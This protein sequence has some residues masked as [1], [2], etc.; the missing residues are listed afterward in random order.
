MNNFKYTMMHDLYERIRSMLIGKGAGSMA[1]VIY[2][3]KHIY[4]IGY[5]SSIEHLCYSDKKY[6]VPSTHAEMDAIRRVI[7]DYVRIHKRKLTANIMIVRYISTCYYAISKPCIDCLK[8]MQINKKYVT[9]R[10]VTYGN[11]EGLVTEKLCDL[12]THHVSR[13]W[14]R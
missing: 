6:H 14:R 8:F 10:N 5:S 7:N 4:S 12:E 9:I 2:K 11:N 3:K 1:E 13:G